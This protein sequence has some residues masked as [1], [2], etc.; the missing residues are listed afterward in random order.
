MSIINSIKESDSV[1]EVIEGNIT[2]YL[3]LEKYLDET[4]AILKKVKH[5]GILYLSA[6]S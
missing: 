5:T 2:E 3:I 6:G 1:F 4:M